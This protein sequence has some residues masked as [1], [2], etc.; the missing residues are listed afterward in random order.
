MKNI[1]R[2]SFFGLL[3][4]APVAAMLPAMPLANGGYVRPVPGYRPFQIFVPRSL[5]MRARLNAAE[6]RIF[7]PVDL[8]PR[9]SGKTLLTKY[10]EDK[11]KDKA[12][13]PRQI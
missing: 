10:F 3:A 2:R 9:R 8:M 1:S 7:V 4:A 11:L 13:A 12:D 6:R 5:L